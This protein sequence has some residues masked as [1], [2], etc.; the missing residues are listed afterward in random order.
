MILAVHTDASYLSEQGSKSR[1]AGHFYLINTNDE[2]FN[3]GA[4]LTL[5]SVIKHVMSSAS[6]AEQAALFYGCKQ[7]VPLRSMLEEMGHQQ[8]NPIPVTTDN[9]TAHGL[10]LGLMTPKASKLNDMRFHWLKCRRA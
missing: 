10:T 1:A 8:T 5:T 4:L 2:D 6:E 7:A 9:A 3:N